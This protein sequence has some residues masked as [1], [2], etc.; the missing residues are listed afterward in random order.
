MSVRGK[1][2]GIGSGETAF[3]DLTCRE[4][5]SVWRFRV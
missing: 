2:L 1:D 5:V 4:Q 3:G